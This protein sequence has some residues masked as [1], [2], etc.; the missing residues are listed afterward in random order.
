MAT[1]SFLRLPEFKTDKE[2]DGLIKALENDRKPELTG[3]KAEKITDEK[4]IRR[5]LDKKRQKIKKDKKG[6]IK[7]ATSS[8]F[9]FPE[10]KTEKEIDGL[11]KALENDRKPNL[12]DAKAETITDEREIKELLGLIDEED[13]IERDV[14]V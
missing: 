9:R 10:F 14:E 12:T 13:N 3:V 7:M 5:I 2:I 8:F 4:R 6:G 11:I 1:S